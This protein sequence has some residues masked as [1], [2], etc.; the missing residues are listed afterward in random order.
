MAR[1]SKRTPEREASIT[2]ALAR[3][4]TRRA[5]AAAAG[6]TE[7]TFERWMARFVGF[8]AAVEK[9]EA[10]AELMHVANVAKAAEDGT[11]TASAW[12]LERRRADE[13][14]RRDRLEVISAVRDLARR[15]GLSAED[16]ARAVEEAERALQELRGARRPAR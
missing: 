16:E 15:A 11:W 1:P 7:R 9:A 13:W 12:W 10:D 6:V 5:A 4:N 8:V 3:G 2:A 14:G